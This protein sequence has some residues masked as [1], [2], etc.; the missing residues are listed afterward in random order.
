MGLK[1]YRLWA[2]GQLDST[3][4]APPSPAAA[5]A[6]SSAFLAAL[7]LRIIS[8]VS[9]SSLRYMRLK[10]AVSMICEWWL[11]VASE[12]GVAVQVDPFESKGLKLGKSPRFQCQ[13]L[14]PGVKSEKQSA[15][16][17]DFSVKG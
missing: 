2:M 15:E 4:R 7:T 1:G 17:R 5:C 12:R 11:V 3:C 14:K 9:A 10:I 13:G 6:F 16:N 8:F